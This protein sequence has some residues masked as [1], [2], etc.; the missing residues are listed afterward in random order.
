MICN[1]FAM[2]TTHTAATIVAALAAT[3]AT[4]APA[5]TADPN[6]ATYSNAAGNVRCEIYQ[7]DGSTETICVSETARQTQPECNPPEQLIPAVTV[8]RDFVGTNCWNQGFV[9]QPQKLSPLQVQRFGTA[10]VIPGFSG[11][12]YVLDIAR[13]TLVRAGSTNAVLFK[14]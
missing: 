1:T 11:N 13:R 9:G 8:G 12:L 2:K 4:L 7:V 6:V 10:T 5:A 3:T 14:I